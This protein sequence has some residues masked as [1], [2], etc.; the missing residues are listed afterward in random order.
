MC[1]KPYERLIKTQSAGL[2]PQSLWF[3]KARRNQELV[4]LI[5]SWLMLM[6]LVQEPHL[7]KHWPYTYLYFKHPA[8]ITPSG[9][10]W[11]GEGRG[12]TFLFSS[13]ETVNRSISQPYYSCGPESAHHVCLYP[14]PPLLKG[15]ISWKGRPEMLL[16][17]TI[18][19][20]VSAPTRYL[21]NRPRKWTNKWIKERLWRHL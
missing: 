14:T 18:P 10:G 17:F 3:I 19:R 2:S 13:Q 1:I 11:D 15:A 12:F 16:S 5:S 21:I 20:A 7:K 6:L 4:F 8:E 9:G